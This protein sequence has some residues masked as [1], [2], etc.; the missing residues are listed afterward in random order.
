MNVEIA[1]SLSAVILAVIALVFFQIAADV[2]LLGG[3]TL[4][5]VTGVVSTDRAFEGV[6]NEGLITVAVLFAVAEGLRQ[7]GGIN[8][9]GQQ[10]LGRP[11]S[12]A[13]AQTRIMIPTVVLSAFLNNTPVVAVLLP[14][15]HDWAKKVQ[16]SVSKLMLPLSYA[17]ILGGMCTLIGTST[18]LVLNDKLQADLAKLGIESE[19]LSMFTIAWVGVPAAVIGMLYLVAVS[20]WLLPERKPAIDQFDDPREYTVEMLIEEGSPL[21]GQTIEAAG[22]RHLPGMFLAE[23]D[24]EGELLAAVSP[25]T[26]LHAADRLVFVGVVESVVDLQ[27]IPGLTP[28]TD[29]VFKL[30]S[31][32]SNRCLL[33]AVVSNYL[34]ADQHDDPGGPIPN[35]I[36]RRRHRRL[37]K[38]STSDREDRRHVVAPGDTLLLEALPTF[39]QVQR[40]SRDFYLVSRIEDSNPPR[41]ESA[42]I[43]R[44]ILVGMVLLVS[45]FGVSMLKASL[46]AAGLM[47]VTKCARGSDMRR[48]IDWSVLITMAAGIGMG[49]A[50]EDS[51]AADLVAG[52]LIKIGGSDPTYALAIVYFVTMLFTN[53]ITAKAAGVLVFPIALAAAAS[54]GVSYMPFAIAV[55]VA[56]AA[57]FATPIGYQTNLMVFGPGGYRYSDF[58]RIGGPLSVLIWGL[59]IIII[60]RVWPFEDQPLES[61]V[62]V[63]IHSAMPDEPVASVSKNLPV[64]TRLASSPTRSEPRSADPVPRGLP[65]TVPVR[66]TGRSRPD[67]TTR[68][69][70]SGR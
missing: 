48:A 24:R 7:T 26:H 60:P 51:G 70:A 14:V 1:L 3:L 53:L 57:S 15:L 9:L 33:E 64:H 18:T 67:P 62:A 35:A 20:R 5:L 6:A 50:M 22:L 46:L 37:S 21:I 61:S 43:A 13:D 36:Q 42:W 30:D 19:G 29:Q 16:M 11:K 66:S 34:S 45:A 10:V 27:K 52:S 41:H 69:T 17:A 32:R 28:A 25:T 38:R 47:V 49:N 39:E 44:A 58:L 2:V 12:V 63:Q 56:A 31:P 65:G 8:F 40:N 23:I 59:S 55:M 54:L 4:L 68:R